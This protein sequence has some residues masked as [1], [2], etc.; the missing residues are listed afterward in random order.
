MERFYLASQLQKEARDD[1][2]ILDQLKKNAIFAPR[3]TKSKTL[4][5]SFLQDKK[6]TFT[7]KEIEGFVNTSELFKIKTSDVDKNEN[8]KIWCDY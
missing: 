7:S 1:E 5:S 3:D 4:V 8:I 6:K 2:D